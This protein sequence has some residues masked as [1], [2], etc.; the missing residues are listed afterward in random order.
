MYNLNNAFHSCLDMVKNAGINPGKIVEVIPNTRAKSRWGQCKRVNGGY[1]ININV[2]LLDERNDYKGLENTLIHEIL[3]TVD[4]CMN[5]GPNWKRAADRIKTAYGLEI[6]R[7]SSKEDKGVAY[8]RE[9]TRN[10]PVKY[11]LKCLDCGHEYKYQRATKAVK[12]PERF[13][14]GHCQGRLELIK[15]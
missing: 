11:V 2:D 5:H 13:R 4:G 14:C 8:K 12:F 9:A 15:M 1:S 3:H 6:K 10:E 7:V